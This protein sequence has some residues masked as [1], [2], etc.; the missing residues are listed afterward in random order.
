M[1]SRV[2]LHNKSF[3][4][5]LAGKEAKRLVSSLISEQQQV[6]ILVF[7][8]LS[9]AEIRAGKVNF[10]LTGGFRGSFSTRMHEK[11]FHGCNDADPQV[12]LVS[13]SG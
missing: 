4:F 11:C 9:A 13:P 6:D 2:W 7:A 1:Y 5:V 12:A 3:F 10:S 8:A